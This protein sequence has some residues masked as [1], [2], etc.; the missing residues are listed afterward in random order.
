MKGVFY[1]SDDGTRC[2]RKKKCTNVDIFDEDFYP[3]EV[4]KEEEYE[5]INDYDEKI[6]DIIKRLIIIKMFIE[7]NKDSKVLND[8]YD[9]SIIKNYKDLL[10]K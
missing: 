3:F 10:F 4:K 2:E 6:K 7:D 5:P 8:F 9:L 1:I